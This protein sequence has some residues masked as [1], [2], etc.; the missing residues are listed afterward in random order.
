M[1]IEKG[2]RSFYIGLADSPIAEMS[3]V[4]SG[5]GLIIIDSTHV[6]AELKGQGAGKLLLEEVVKWARDENLKIVPLCTF[7]KAQMEK[8]KEY[9]DLVYKSN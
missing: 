1:K 9:H 7:A 6:G 8:N 4:E 2:D 5:E 3:Y